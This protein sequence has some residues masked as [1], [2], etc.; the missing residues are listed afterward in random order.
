M[1]ARLHLAM[2]RLA[3]AERERLWAIV[4]A[5]E[6]GLSIRQIACATGVS[7]TR[8]HQLLQA[9][10]ARALPVWL[11]QQWLAELE[12]PPRR[13][14]RWEERAASRQA[15]GLPPYERS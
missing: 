15:L 10:E 13:L 3:D 2:T 9:D 7:P 4:A 8:I 12:P 1:I 6:A 14:R 5:K 11:S